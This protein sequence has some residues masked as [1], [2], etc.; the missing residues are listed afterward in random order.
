MQALQSAST[1]YVRRVT[2]RAVASAAP[3]APVPPPPSAANVFV[4][5]LRSPTGPMTTHFWGPVTNWGLSLAALK[6]MSKPPELVSERMTVALMVYSLL[7]MRF[8]LRVQPTNYLLFACHACNETA[9]T[10]QLQRKYGGVDLFYKKKDGAA[11]AAAA[12]ASRGL[13]DAL[14]DKPAPKSA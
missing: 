2:E 5:F 13:A 9:Q 6:D 8:A 10:Y 14:P 3:A 4:R 7:F 12:T 11:A 1:R